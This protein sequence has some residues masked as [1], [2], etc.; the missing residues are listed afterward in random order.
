MFFNR[1]VVIQF[2]PVKNCFIVK[3]SLSC[4]LNDRAEGEPL[5]GF[6][7]IEYLGLCMAQQ[8]QQ[9]HQPNQWQSPK[10]RFAW[11]PQ[12]FQFIFTCSIIVWPG[13]RDPSKPY[14]YIE[15]CRVLSV[16]G[17]DYSIRQMSC[18]WYYFS[19]G[20]ILRASR[21]CCSPWAAPPLIVSYQR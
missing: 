15:I 19:A 10:T 16:T 2:R 8:R 17:I 4:T 9:Q 1:R 18:P 5:F 11:S 14:R 7:Y 12:P 6:L 13:L 3:E 20:T 21:F